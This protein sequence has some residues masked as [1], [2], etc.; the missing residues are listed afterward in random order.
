VLTLAPEPSIAY[1]GE[2][3]AISLTRISSSNKYYPC[4]FCTYTSGRQSLTPCVVEA[5][6]AAR[7]VNRPP[8]TLLWL[9]LHVLTRPQRLATTNGCPKIPHGVFRTCPVTSADC[10][11]TAAQAPKH[12]HTVRFGMHQH[13]DG[14]ATYC[15][16]APNHWRSYPVHVVTHAASRRF[17]APV[18]KGRGISTTPRP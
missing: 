11:A 15:I 3:S 14:T 8:T 4:K 13:G 12:Q 1:T 2:T 16:K 7:I 6:T 10:A 17:V 18:G 9:T 5:V